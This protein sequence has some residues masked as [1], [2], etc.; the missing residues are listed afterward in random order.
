MKQKKPTI[1]SANLPPRNS[2]QEG[3]CV[4]KVLRPRKAEEKVLLA[5]TN[6]DYELAL[7]FNRL[8]PHG[9]RSAFQKQAD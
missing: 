9:P 5:L 8:Y 2:R 4:M 6:V 3:G 1:V 7:F